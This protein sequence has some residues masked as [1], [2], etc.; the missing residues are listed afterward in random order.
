MQLI[1]CG[2]L[3]YNKLGKSVHTKKYCVIILILTY[4]LVPLFSA[5]KRVHFRFFSMN[6]TENRMQNKH[7]IHDKPLA[8]QQ[9]TW[10][11]IRAAVV[12]CCFTCRKMRDH[13]KR[14]NSEF[15][16][17][18]LNTKPSNAKVISNDWCFKKY[19][20][21]VKNKTQRSFTHQTTIVKHYTNK[22]SYCLGKKKLT[23][24]HK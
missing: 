16:L 2:T 22:R 1:A 13:L 8:A 10:V 14:V 24:T 15:Q 11:S 4:F 12:I 7:E 17:T 19:F 18:D 23:L 6:C 20:F 21:S 9:Q 5:D 3:I